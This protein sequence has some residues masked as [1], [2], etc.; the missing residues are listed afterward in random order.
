MLKFLLFVLYFDCFNTIFL[1]FKFY[2]RLIYDCLFLLTKNLVHSLAHKELHHFLL[3]VQIFVASYRLIIFDS[4][5]VKLNNFFDDL[6]RG[7]ICKFEINLAIKKVLSEFFGKV[8]FGCM[9]F[10]HRICMLR[11]AFVVLTILRIEV[12]V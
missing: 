10:K 4:N 6:L 8:Y 9:S 1:G 3:K 11:I 12:V 5:R 7:P 2:L